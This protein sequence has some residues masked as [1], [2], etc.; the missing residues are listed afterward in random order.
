MNWFQWCKFSCLL[1]I[2]FCNPSRLFET[3]CAVLLLISIDLKLHFLYYNIRR[4]FALSNWLLRVEIPSYRGKPHLEGSENNLLVIRDAIHKFRQFV[5][6]LRRMTRTMKFCQIV[7]IRIS[8][9]KL[10]LKQT[11]A[12]WS[13]FFPLLFVA[14]LMELMIANLRACLHKVLFKTWKN[15]FRKH[16]VLK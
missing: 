4:I 12:M 10:C 11:W 1:V 3:R 2:M 5:R 8:F 7:V 16:Q 14:W 9:V 13:C 15:R 6:R